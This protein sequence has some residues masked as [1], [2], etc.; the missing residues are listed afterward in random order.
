MN[1]RMNCV[2]MNFWHQRVRTSDLDSFCRLVDIAAGEAERMSWGERRGVE[3]EAK[4]AAGG[5]RER[6]KMV[7]ILPGVGFQRSGFNLPA[8]MLENFVRGVGDTGVDHEIEVG[9]RTVSESRVCRQ[10]K[11]GSLEERDFDVGCR[12]NLDRFRESR[13]EMRELEGPDHREA[14]DL[15]A[16]LRGNTSGW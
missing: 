4:A 5:I 1:C 9:H 11:R 8:G 2:V 3:L 7:V 10:R 15:A 6:W 12:Q 13:F 16:D 14:V